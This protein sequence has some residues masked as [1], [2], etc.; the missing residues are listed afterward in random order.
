MTQEQEEIVIEQIKNIICEVYEVIYTGDMK[1]EEK[2]DGY[3]LS[4]YLNRDYITPTCKMYKQCTS[5]DEF[6]DFVR[7][8]LLNRNLNLVKYYVGTKID[9]NDYKKRIRRER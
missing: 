8:E 7:E 6:L 1:I 2:P 3:S 4:L 9:L 5:I